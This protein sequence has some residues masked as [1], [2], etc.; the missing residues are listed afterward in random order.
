[1]KQTQITAAK[2][3]RL[4]SKQDNTTG[5]TT[6]DIKLNKN[7]VADSIKVNKDGRDGEDGVSITGPTGVAGQDSNN[8]KVGITGC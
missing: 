8:G 7:L 4:S 5:N 6:I 3:L 1:M 2:T